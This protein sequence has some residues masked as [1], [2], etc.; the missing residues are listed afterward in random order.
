M[1]APDN[2]TKSSG[3]LWARL[4]AIFSRKRSSPPTISSDSL[5][6]TLAF[7][8]AE[9]LEEGLHPVSWSEV[10]SIDVFKRDLITVDLICMLFTSADGR[11]VELHEEMQG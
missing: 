4:K 2:P 3:G 11:Q 10:E 9:R 6:L 7:D 1:G 8:D 5:G